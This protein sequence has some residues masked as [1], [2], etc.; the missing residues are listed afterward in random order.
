MGACRE[1]SPA[2]QDPRTSAEAGPLAEETTT[3]PVDRGAV[4]VSGRAAR[5]TMVLAI[6]RR[7]PPQGFALRT[8]RGLTRGILARECAPPGAATG[9][10][11]R[12]LRNSLGVFSSEFR[13][14]G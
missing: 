10:A 9:K 2:R 13:F 8:L 7:S 6:R 5:D 1:D 4:I 14:Y 11:A 12:G 3:L